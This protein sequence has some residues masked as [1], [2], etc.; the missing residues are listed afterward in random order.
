MRVFDS[1][2]ALFTDYYQLTMAQGYLLTGKAEKKTVFDF[3]F[4]ENPY[5]N[6]YVVFAGLSD[7]LEVLEK[8]RFEDNEIEYLGSLG[9]GTEFLRYLY[10]FRFSGTIHAM[11]EGEVV[12]PYEPIVRIEGTLFETQLIETIL[13]NL[14]NFQSLIATKASRIRFAAGNRRIMDVGLRRAQGL[15]GIQASKAAII[16]GLDSTSNLYAAFRYS[17]NIAGTQSHSWVQSFTDELSAFRAYADIYPENCVLLVDTYNVVMSGIPN[18]ITV[19]KEMEGKGQKLKAIR[20]DT[21]DLGYLSKKARAMLNAERLEYVQIYVSNQLDE[22]LI[23]KLIQQGAPID[24]FG[25]GTR[26]LTAYD[27]PVFQ[28]VYKQSVA[29]DKPTLKYAESFAK[30]TLPG[31]KKVVRFFDSMG[32]FDSDG[33]MMDTEEDIEVFYDPIKTDQQFRVG[34]MTGRPLLQ[35]V[36]EHGHII[37]TLPTPTESA[38][39]LSQRFSCLP[40]VCKRFDK[41]EQFKVGISPSLMRLRSFLFEQVQKETI[42]KK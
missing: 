31:L 35:K 12:F 36:M 21:G 29:G 5:G 25:I 4:R 28:G 9:F 2:A 27:C 3:F 16:G 30:T 33:I 34:G 24:A 22:H 7:L 23:N 37:G 8:L 15:G 17:L 39:Y 6:G 40:P 14:L 1:H 19:A 32:L 11:K 38:K 20:L 41:P 26:L 10:N 13:L 42:T 18:A